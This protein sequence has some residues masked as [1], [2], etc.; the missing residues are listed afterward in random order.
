MKPTF[1]LVSC[2]GVFPLSPSLDTVGPMTRG[3][4]DNAILL[5]AMAEGDFL[6]GLRSG[7]KGLRIGVIEHFYTH[8]AAANAEQVRAIGEAAGVL[9]ELG[10]TVQPVRLSPLRA[11]TECG[12]LIQQPEQYAVH[13]AWLKTRAQDYCELSRTKLLPGATIPASEYI[14]ALN[15]RK[16]LRAEFDALMRDLDAVITLSSFEMP[17]PIERPELVA[18]TYMR[19][20]RM[21]FNVTGT[22]ALSVPTGFSEERLPLA[23]QIAG[24]AHDEATLY[25]IAW[26]YCDATGWTDRRPAIAGD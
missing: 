2:D 5:Q 17:C 22:P 13:E 4:E 19:H 23:M 11:W 24:K 9:R 20:A 8:D 16:A 1:G 21:P 10:A 12:R 7:V 15:M 18:K 14:A 26:A 25:R 3:V 6:S